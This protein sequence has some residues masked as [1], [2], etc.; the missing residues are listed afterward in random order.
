MTWQE[1]FPFAQCRPIQ[2]QG[3]DFIIR[4]LSE[5][6]DIL[7]EAPTGV[8]KSAIA[9]A[10]ARWAANTG[11]STYI[12]TATIQL[13]NQYISDFACLGLK[14][15]HAKRHY[16]C[17]DWHQC[18][19][20]SRSDCEEENWCPY[21]AAK[22]EFEAAAFSIAN[23][24]FLLTCARFRRNW[25]ARGL[26]IFDEGHLLHN[27]I[28]DGY[29]FDIPAGE[30][31]FFPAEGGEREWLTKH[32]AGW[33]SN[34]IGSLRMQFSVAR[35][36]GDFAAITRLARAL[37]RT[38]AKQQ[39]LHWILS[40]EEENWLFDQQDTCLS[41]KPVWAAPLA[42]PLLARIG[43]KRIY[44]SATLPGFR[45]QCR[46]LGID[47]A[48]TRSLALPS[49][50]PVRNRLVHICPVVEW[51]FPRRGSE[52]AAVCTA[53]EKILA[54]HPNDRGL[55][56]VSSYPQAQEVVTRSGN[57]RLIMHRNSHEKESRLEEMF[58]RP[59]AVLVSPSSHEGLDLYGERS[60]FQVVAKLPFV[61]LGD[62]RVKRRMETD[63]NWYTLNTAHRFI[64]ACGRSVRSDT[65]YATTYVLD[66]A[67][68]WFYRRAAK[69]FPGYVSDALRSG[70]V[71]LS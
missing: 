45:D 59:G 22:R 42:P 34:R 63:G 38:E 39:N 17:P 40:D 49:P 47:P 65:D 29:A 23:A 50:F 15:L 26:A 7:L 2:A 43:R 3:L 67:F 19:V 14:Q 5:A 31:E 21:R 11:A 60:R 71:N 6:D 37:E 61:G 52:I 1:F 8:G 18:D 51:S 68:D 30:V 28:C 46:Y 69:F 24:A 25:A 48:K 44:L 53:L 70:E 13:E 9:I 56:H 12:S 54:L 62:K 4:S 64:Q 33:L 58:A 55:V 10:L 36:Q 27:T 57:R 66:A 16:D 35:Q 41:V 32:Y 20:G